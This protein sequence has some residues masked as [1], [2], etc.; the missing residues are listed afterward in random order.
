MYYKGAELYVDDKD[1]RNPIQLALTHNDARLTRMAADFARVSSLL[2]Y[3]KTNE[4]MQGVLEREEST[5]EKVDLTKL[6]LPNKLK[7]HQPLMKLLEVSSIKLPASQ[8]ISTKIMLGLI[9][10]ELDRRRSDH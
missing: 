1:G 8:R 9:R 5:Q 3:Y 6:L 10:R 2:K 4:F 7:N